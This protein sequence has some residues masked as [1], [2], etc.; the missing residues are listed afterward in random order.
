MIDQEQQACEGHG[1]VCSRRCVLNVDIGA[2]IGRQ[3][4]PSFPARL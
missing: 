2:K 1:N 3:L 4:G